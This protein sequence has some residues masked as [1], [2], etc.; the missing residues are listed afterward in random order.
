M[1]LS[2]VLSQFF[3]YFL[4]AA[5]IENMVLTTGFGSSVLLRMSR[6]RRNLLPFSIILCIFS[7]LTVLICY[8]LDMLIG[9]GFIAKWIRPFM[10]VSVTALLYIAAVLL[11]NKKFPSVYAR[12]SRMLPLAA[13][14]NLV[15]GIAM[16]VN[17]Q[18]ALSLSGTLG[19][20][21]GACMGYLLLSWLTAEGIE[22]LDNPDVP[23]AFRGLPAVLLYLGILTLALMGFKFGVSLI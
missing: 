15:V 9:T 20:S 14:N 1:Q 21:L 3:T 5:F 2:T 6:K 18:F 10:I 7:V 19:L 23:K 12:V 17:Q 11:L 8:P 22:R 16:V 4:A 13:F